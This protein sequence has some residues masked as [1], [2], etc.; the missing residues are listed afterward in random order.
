MRE[1]LK[2][3]GKLEELF[4]EIPDSINKGKIYLIEADNFKQKGSEIFCFG[5]FIRFKLLS[6][7]ILFL[8]NDIS[9]DSI[10][11]IF[12]KLN[13]PNSFKKNLSTLK[14]QY[15]NDI[16][17]KFSLAVPLDK[18]KGIKD[19]IK[20]AIFKEPPTGDRKFLFRPKTK[21]EIEQ[22]NLKRKEILEQAKSK[23]QQER[24]KRQNDDLVEQIKFTKRLTDLNTRSIQI[25]SEY[26]PGAVIFAQKQDVGNAFV[27]DLLKVAEGL[28]NKKRNFVLENSIQNRFKLI[29]LIVKKD[30]DG[31]NVIQNWDQMSKQS[32][33]L[34]VTLYQI[35]LPAINWLLYNKSGVENE[36]YFV[37]WQD[38]ALNSVEKVI[39]GGT[40][41][42][43]V[44]MRKEEKLKNYKSLPIKAI[45][46]RG[47]SK[48]GDDLFRMVNE[49]VI[50][51]REFAN[52]LQKAYIAKKS[53]IGK[54]SS[55]LLKLDD[56][57]SILL[58][59]DQGNAIL[60]KF[61]N[62]KSKINNLTKSD[63]NP[64]YTYYSSVSNY[65][66]TFKQAEGYQKVVE[67]AKKLVSDSLFKG[68]QNLKSLFDGN[69]FNLFNSNLLSILF[70]GS[71]IQI[72]DS[73]TTPKENLASLITSLKQST[74][75]PYKKLL[76]INL[77]NLQQP[78]IKINPNL[79]E[80]ANSLESL[81]REV[82]KMQ[83]IATISTDKSSVKTC[84][85]C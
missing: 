2:G 27:P 43:K 63:S 12:I 45:F 85:C 62:V 8:G 73:A 16:K 28:K 1:L 61:N 82:S 17:L 55:E 78:T 49:L 80:F 48:I 35:M 64:V 23:E 37:N 30:S 47:G 31:T 65:D 69:Q 83:D 39:K 70:L 50:S 20:Q 67:D 84:D 56:D 25:N 40:G 9:K 58:E 15:Y 24:E 38:M 68:S 11:N 33:I 36:Q 81:A 57:P 7:I 77:S 52:T 76:A 32:G 71:N 13:L 53:S 5:N 18:P 54:T 66:K 79:V 14:S 72:K 6:G 44:F 34:L 10:D 22:D 26:P 19:S 42:S 74:N 46:K 4:Q 41:G 75:I 60:R 3:G 59:G 29:G 21:E 51:S